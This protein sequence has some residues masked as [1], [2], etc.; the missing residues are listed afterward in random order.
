MIVCDHPKTTA[1]WEHVTCDDCRMIRTGAAGW[2]I[3][4]C[5]WFKSLDEARFYERYGRLPDPI[6]PVALAG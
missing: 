3:A 5:R 1:N 6:K 2:T 4:R